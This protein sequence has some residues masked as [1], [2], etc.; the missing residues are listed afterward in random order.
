M[1]VFFYIFNATLL[2]LHELESAYEKEWEILKLPVKLTG[3]ILLHIP[4]LFL[5]F[6]GL[7]FIIK[8]PQTR[9]LISILAG[10]IGFIP[11]LVHK[12]IINKKEHFNKKISNGLI[13]GNMISGI[14]LMV[15]GLLETTEQ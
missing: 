6:Y 1:L 11:F 5:F 7:Y 14:A 12:I 8:Y 4:L 2:I 10:S 9:S 15:V 13:F 3:F